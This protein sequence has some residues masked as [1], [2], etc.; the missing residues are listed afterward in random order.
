MKDSNSGYLI[1][2][3]RESRRYVDNARDSIQKGKLDTSAN[4]Y[5]DPKYVR[6]AGNY[7]WLGVLLALES[8]F[9][10]NQEKKGRV[11]VNDYKTIIAT[12]DKK[13]LNW[14]VDGYNVMHLSMT[15]DGIQL[16]STCDE[17][18]RLANAII[19]RCAVLLPK[20]A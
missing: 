8:V 1:D 15:Y 3:I 7:L 12:R 20:T 6:A 10:I 2:P 13:L 16:K 11:D 19:D 18:F 9:H 17:G 14:V 5:E 4:R